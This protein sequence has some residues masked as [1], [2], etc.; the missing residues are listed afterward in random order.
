MNEALEQHTF[1][2]LLRAFSYPGQVLPVEDA[3]RRVLAA[4]LDRETGLADPHG[5]VDADDWLRLQARRVPVKDGAFVLMRGELAPA[6]APRLG[7]LAQPELGATIIVRVERL[8]AGQDL[9]LRG[10]G[11]DGAATLRV[12]GLHHGWHGARVEWNAGFPMGVD[13]LLVDGASL[14]AIP[15]TTQLTAEGAR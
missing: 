5:L 12:D 2:Q 11:I 8:G 15:R 13:L 10:P 14:A 3:L 4:L 9:I 1:R 7:T 6:I